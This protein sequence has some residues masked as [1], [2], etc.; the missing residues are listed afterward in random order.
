MRR[1][2]LSHVQQRVLKKMSAGWTLSR[3]LS[4]PDQAELGRDGEIETINNGTVN[5]LHKKGLIRRTRREFPHQW[6]QLSIKGKD[7]ANGRA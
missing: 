4:E 7:I 3:D 2:Q 1:V 5:S 6:F